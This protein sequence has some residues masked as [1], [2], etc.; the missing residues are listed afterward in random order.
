MQIDVK[1]LFENEGQKIP[2]AGVVDFGDLEIDGL[3][4]A[5]IEGEVVNRAGI[6]SVHYSAACRMNYLCDRCLK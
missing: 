3:S 6:V 2:F 4:E 5:R 1:Q